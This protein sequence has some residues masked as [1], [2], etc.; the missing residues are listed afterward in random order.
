MVNQYKIKENSLFAR[1]A[2][3]YMKTNNIAMVLGKTI[4]LSGVSKEHFLNSS[5]WLA[6]ELVHVEQFK[7]YGFLRF[8]L[9]Y[10]AE[11]YKKGYHNNKFEVEARQ[12]AG[13]E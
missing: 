12:R 6:H 13:E 10:L 4:H 5:K 1:T 9:L 8:L 3:Y 11:S 7:R 2:R